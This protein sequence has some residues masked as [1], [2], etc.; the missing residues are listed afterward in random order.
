MFFLEKKSVVRA[1]GGK[2][3]GSVQTSWDFQIDWASIAQAVVTLSFL[4][5][6]LRQ[7]LQ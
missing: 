6:S 1:N 3:A 4:V 2:V 7:W 5:Y